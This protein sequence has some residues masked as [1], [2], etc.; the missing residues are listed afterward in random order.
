M[1]IGLL[2]FEYPPETGFGGIGSYTYYQ[3]RALARLGHTVHVLAG[4]KERTP[5][6]TLERGGISV[7][8]YHA[9]GRTM[10]VL[11][12][13]GRWQCWW[14]RQRLQN[15][16]SMYRALR[17]LQRRY[18]FDI[19]EMPECGAEGLLINRLT[20]IPSVVR[21]HSPSRLIMPLYDVPRA[22]VAMC[23]W[24]EQRAIAGATA[25]SSC[26]RFLADE[27]KSKMAVSAP[28][29]VI[30]NGLDLPLFDQETSLGVFER[31]GIPKDKIK[32]FFS[33]RMERRKGI[34]LC[35]QIA[36][37]ILKEHDVSFVFAGQDLFDYMA[38]TLM[39]SLQ[40]H[41]LKGSVHYVGKLDLHEVRD[42]L[43]ASDI[44]LLPSLWENFPYSCLEAMASRCAIVASGQGGVPEMIV[45]GESGL[46]ATAGD[47]AS[48]VQKLKVLIRDAEMRRRLGNSARR[49]A[50]NQFSDERVAR[51]S[52]A[53]YESVLRLRVGNG[54]R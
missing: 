12:I 37:A 47:P 9:G 25:L 44:F 18:Q 33:G 19:L 52:V 40:S 21:F 1:N 49:T 2:S 17:L 35:G 30:P 34:H 54:V 51:L 28:V 41:S 43:R 6:Y 16:W 22:D 27:V 29:T 39:P 53:F 23:S 15:G 14:S 31:H 5:L 4:S 38:G 48:F 7:H 32:I 20:G 42:C 26:S 45:D 3:A 36:T 50:E 11:G 46:L 13:P 10:Q 8:R 24:I